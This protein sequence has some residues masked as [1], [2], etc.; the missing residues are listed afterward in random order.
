LPAQ[1]GDFLTHRQHRCGDGGFT[2]GEER[3][4][5]EHPNTTRQSSRTATNPIMLPLS[6]MTAHHPRSEL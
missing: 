4:P 1:H 3:M 5:A 6:D 2:S